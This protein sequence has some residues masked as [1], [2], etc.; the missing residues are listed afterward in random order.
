MRHRPSSP[1]HTFF[2]TL[3]LILWLLLMQSPPTPRAAAAEEALP[4][5]QTFEALQARARQALPAQMQAWRAEQDPAKKKALRDRIIEAVAVLF[6][7]R[8]AVIEELVAGGPVAAREIKLTSATGTTVVN[9]TPLKVFT[10]IE[11]PWLDRRL[12]KNAFE[13]WTAKEGWLFD[14][15][16]KMLNHAAVPRRDGNGLEWFGAFLPDGSWVTT[17]LWTFDKTL[18][19]YSKDGKFLKD[20]PTENFA[21]PDSEGEPAGGLIGWARAD[22][23][24][25]GWVFAVMGTYG[26]SARYVVG[27]DFKPQPIQGLEAW[28]R[29][30]P[31]Q[32][33][34]RYSQV[35]SDDGTLLLSG[36]EAGH[37]RDVGLPDYFLARTG[38]PNTVLKIDRENRKD[39]LFSLVIPGHARSLGGFW[40][41]SHNVYIYGDNDPD[42]LPNNGS[43]KLW[44]LDSAGTCQGWLYGRCLADSTDGRSMLFKIPGG[45]VLTL[46]PDLQIRQ[47]RQFAAPDGTP[48]NPQSLYPDL[49]L[50]LFRRQGQLVLASWPEP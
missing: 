5:E 41:G 20:L 2:S 21:P 43:P 3:T 26:E 44:F 9:V 25:K 37:G 8:D 11:N 13:V 31:R 17:D 12:T 15:A 10:G 38:A 1:T 36:W 28:T 33:G 19:F 46:A 35:P 14:A 45:R 22:K 40:P 18:F 23:E 50:G 42:K 6:E 24:G 32:L 34:T 39:A 4:A 48:L 29:C 47:L 7:E 30:Y 16:G 27:P 49:H